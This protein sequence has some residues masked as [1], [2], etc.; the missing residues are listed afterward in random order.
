MIND[1]PC[2]YLLFIFAA[3][4]TVALEALAGDTGIKY[5]RKPEIMADAAYFIFQHTSEQMTGQFLIDEEV[6]M[7]AGITDMDRYSVTPGKGSQLGI[8]NVWFIFV[9]SYIHVLFW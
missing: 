2:I 7:K 1:T 9:I 3:I 6:L 8:L 4:A 5:S